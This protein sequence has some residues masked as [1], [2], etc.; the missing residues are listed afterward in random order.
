MGRP[1][2]TLPIDGRPVIA[3]VVTA[4]LAGGVNRVLVVAPPETIEGA[5]PL[6]RAARD[7]G[8]NVLVAPAP[9]A[10]MRATIEVGLR[11]LLQ[12]SPAPELLVLTPGDSPGLTPALVAT[13]LHLRRAEPEAVFVPAFSGR[14]GHPLLLPWPLATQIP[15]LPPNVGVNALLARHANL[16][17]LVPLDDPGAVAD[18]DTPEDYR[19]WSGS[20]DRDPD[21]R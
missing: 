15:D 2:L 16:V 9:T 6:R 12:S 14:R 11:E 18:L 3:R 7:A 21:R 20:A 17:R 19:R 5:T 1:K 4:L 10:D 8:A 13:L